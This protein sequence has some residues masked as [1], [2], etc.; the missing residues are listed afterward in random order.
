[1]EPTILEVLKTGSD[2][3]IDV[4]KDLV[5][6]CNQKD[7]KMSLVYFFEQKPTSV[8]R[9]IGVN[10]RKEFV[11]D[12]TS[13]SIDVYRSHGLGL[14]H[15]NLNKFSGLNDANYKNVRDEISEIMKAAYVENKSPDL[16]DTKDRP[17][18]L[19]SLAFQKMDLREL[20]NSNA[21]EGTCSWLFGEGFFHSWR[22][23]N[24]V[25]SIQGNPGADKTT[26]VKA[27]VSRLKQDLA[28]QNVAIIGYSFPQESYSASSSN[29]I[30]SQTIIEL[31]KSLLQ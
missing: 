30:S 7:V 5:V 28:G 1:M 10:G 24:G 20:N 3:L 11:V 15:F 19:K 9:I 2:V 21:H 25:L 12:E 23:S 31:Y 4:R 13:G 16:R 26:L 18:L 8:G 14:D 6:L 17:G 22:L 27:V 29:E